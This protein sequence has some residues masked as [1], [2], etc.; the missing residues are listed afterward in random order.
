MKKEN[1]LKKN[2]DF[3]RIIKIKQ[4]VGCSTLIIYYLKNELNYTRIGISCGKKIGN[5]V[6]RNRTKRQV[7]SL[8]DVV[9]DYKLSMDYIVI[10]RNKFLEQ[11]YEKNLKDLKYLLEKINKNIKQG[12]LK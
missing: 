7:R 10:V 2:Q 3:E 4:S 9:I 6:I 5:A 1:S 8:L 12:E 11:D